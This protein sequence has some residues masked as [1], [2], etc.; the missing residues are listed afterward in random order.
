MDTSEFGLANDVS[1]VKLG[2]GVN[3]VAETCSENVVTGNIFG[4][5]VSTTEKE[6][7]ITS[8]SLMLNSVVDISR[9]ALELVDSVLMYNSDS[10]GNGIR[11][12]PPLLGV[13]VTIVT[14][15]VIIAEVSAIVVDVGVINA[16][17]GVI[18]AG[19]SV[20]NAGVSVIVT[21]LESLPSAG[22]VQHWRADNYDL[23]ASK[24][25][26]LILILSLSPRKNQSHLFQTP[27]LNQILLQ[28][29]L[30]NLETALHRAKT[31]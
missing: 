12:L 18:N 10:D 25:Y 31:Q 3:I 29:N 20:I 11:K 17:V 8:L 9:G 30:Q 26:L 1:S 5:N 2:D 16:G 23:I 13:G 7:R 27:N 19:V 22:N 21:E 14:L 24:T 15:D 4:V 6:V 28:M